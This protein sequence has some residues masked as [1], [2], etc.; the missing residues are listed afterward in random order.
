MNIRRLPKHKI[1]LKIPRQQVLDRWDALPDNLKEAL[2][3]ESNSN[4]VWQIGTLNHLPEEKISIMAMIVGAV[5]FGFLHLDDLT[6]EIQESLNLN[7]QIANSISR[8]INRKIFAPIRIDLE[9]IYSPVTAMPEI[10]PPTKPEAEIKPLQYGEVEPP[11]APLPV[12]PTIP[13]VPEAQ[14]I[15]TA[16]REIPTAQR[17]IPADKP[18]MILQETEAKPVGERKRG[19]PPIIGWF[20]KEKPK[21]TEAPVKVQIEEPFDAAQGKEKKEPL[22]AKTEAPKQKVIHYRE[23]EMPTPFGK[24]GTQPP[25]EIPSQ[26]IETPAVKTEPPILEVQPPK[27]KIPTPIIKEVE[28]LKAEPAKPEEP[29]AKPEESK[30]INLDTFRVVKEK[31]TNFHE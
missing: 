20:Q 2:F 25:K 18:F 4:I 10:K 29:K 9:K 23:V 28:P 24:P 8:E 16:Q 1:M 12:T 17:E 31:N 11:A 22:V 5:I 21:K 3:S 13:T 14:K 19:V 30:V 7:P 6:R 15:P 27:I 26:K